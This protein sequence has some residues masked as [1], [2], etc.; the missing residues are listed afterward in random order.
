MTAVNYLWNPINDNIVEEFD[1]TGN[2]IVEYTTEPNQFGDVISQYRD[3]Q[4]SFY[5]TDG[6]G[7]TLA[8][9]NANGD[10]TDTYAYSAF[11][12]VTARTGSTVNPFQHIGQRGYYR[13]SQTGE[14]NLRHRILATTFGR[15]LSVDPIRQSANNWFV[16]VKSNPMRF[17]D[18]SGQVAVCIPQEGEC[19]EAQCRG[20]IVS[21]FPRGDEEDP[22]LGIA[23]EGSCPTFFTR[24]THFD[25][26]WSFIQLR[27]PSFCKDVPKKDID[28]RVKESKR[29]L[30]TCPDGKTCSNLRNRG[31]ALIMGD[32]KTFSDVIV[33][34]YDKITPDQDLILSDRPIVAGQSPCKVKIKTL[35]VELV[36]LTLY[37]NCVDV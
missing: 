2:T 24:K 35:I 22:W 15:F 7:S 6:Q 1:D 26:V 16:Y 28:A 32:K 3:G 5:H 18:P 11:G 13:D 37:G 23:F 14:S 34:M 20:R 4:E 30:R 9:T 10:V 19:G 17:I 25:Q 21:P 36:V 12:E 8:L 33:T 29:E 31:G 27:L